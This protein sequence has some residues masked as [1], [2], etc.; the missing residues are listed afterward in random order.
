[1]RRILV[2]CWSLVLA[3]QAA[4]GWAFQSEPTV[5]EVL[6]NHV[7]ALGGREALEAVQSVVAR[8]KIR[9][10]AAGGIEGDIVMYQVTGRFALEMDLGPLGNVR[11]GSD[12][13]VVWEITPQGPRVLEG[14]ERNN[15][16]TTN[17]Q[18]FAELNWSTE[19]YQGTLELKGKETVDGR[20]AYHVDFTPR[21]G[22][23]MTRF[24]DAQSWL[25]VKT[26]GT[27]ENPNVGRVKIEARPS[28]YK[29]VDGV[30]QP[31]LVQFSANGAESYS[32]EI[33]DLKYN[34]PIDDSQFA[35]PAEIAE[36]VK[37]SADKER[38]AEGKSSDKGGGK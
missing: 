18:P 8:G 31:F 30:L 32:I 33:E 37:D 14:N 6:A 25:V 21:E 4:C 24:F 34:Q 7:K 15:L 9:L 11:Q 12:G 5:D 1:M 26:V 17:G 38:P 35:L 36:L 22:L 23:P 10:K 28:D 16:L 13:E 19:R 20:E 27:Q 29:T 2:L 3:S